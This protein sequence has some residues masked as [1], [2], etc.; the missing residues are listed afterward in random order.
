MDPDQEQSDWV[1]T[2]AFTYISH[3]CSR[4]HE[5]VAFQVIIFPV[6]LGVTLQ[7]EAG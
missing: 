3:I 5:Q 2:F 4:R 6:L 1:H 7:Q